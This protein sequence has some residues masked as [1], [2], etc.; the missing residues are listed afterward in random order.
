MKKIVYTTDF[1]E[2]SVA[3]LKYAQALGKLLK[4][5]VIAL[6]VYSNGELFSGPSHKLEK[7]QKYL[8]KLEG[9][10]REH[11]NEPIKNLDLT[12][13]AVQGTDV[14]A[15]IMDFVRDM[16]VYMLVMGAC[17]TGTL[18]EIVLGSTTK[19]MLSIS[20]F[21]VLAIPSNFEYGPLKKVIYT[22]MFYREDIKNIYELAKIIAPLE[23]EIVV[24]HVTHKDELDATKQLEKFKDKV[25]KAVDYDKIDYHLLFSDQVFEALQHYI[26]DTHPDMAVMLERI[27]GTEISNIFYRDKVKRMQSCTKIPILSFRV[28]K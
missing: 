15:A 19:R 23:V 16:D 10:C 4:T 12:M 8:D 3:A 24:V 1:S 14:P 13:A 18:K 11:L 6:H 17:G 9:F 22:S 5:D 20:R 25:S 21:P 27:K 7:R 28:N 26:E 2:N